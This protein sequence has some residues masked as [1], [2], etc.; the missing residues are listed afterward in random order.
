[1]RIFIFIF[2]QY[3]SIKLYLN[4]KSTI[5]KDYHGHLL[6]VTIKIRYTS[7]KWR[8]STKLQYRF[9]LFNLG[10]KSASAAQFFIEDIIL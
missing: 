5:N 9:C 7:S 2:I 3:F 8:W 10:H 1:M 6:K 4:I